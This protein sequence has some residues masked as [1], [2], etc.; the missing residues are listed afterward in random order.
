MI[1]ILI[2]EPYIA[3][4]FY[5]SSALSLF[6]PDEYIFKYSYV[7]ESCFQLWGDIVDWKNCKSAFFDHGFE[8]LQL[9]LSVYYVF[10]T[11][12]Y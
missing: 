6:S 2:P 7:K 3:L 9:V 8:K 11:T 10:P 12:F 5:L 1:L 4:A